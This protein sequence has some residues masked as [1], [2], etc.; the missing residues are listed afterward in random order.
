MLADYSETKTVNI[1]P[2]FFNLLRLDRPTV[3]GITLDDRC[4][5]I[6][7]SIACLDL[8][9]ERKSV[10][11]WKLSGR[12]EAVYG[13]PVTL[14]RSRSKGQTLA[15]GWGNFGAAQLMC[16]TGTLVSSTI[17]QAESS[18]WMFKSPL[19]EG[20]DNTASAPLQSAHTA[21]IT[22]KVKR[23]FSS[24]VK[25]SG[26]RTRCFSKSVRLSVR[27]SVTLR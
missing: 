8:T 27:V 1:G 22:L 3:W 12:K 19:T 10:G 9:R 15:G 26:C 7:L 25:C 6:R 4:L 23:M 13:W 14:L 21:C 11:S 16:F 18:V 2:G 20:G 24:R 5:S 17:T